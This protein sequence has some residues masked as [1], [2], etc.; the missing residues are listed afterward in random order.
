MELK[1]TYCCDGKER[2]TVTDK[3]VKNF[4]KYDNKYFCSNKCFTN[5][6]NEK[7]SNKRA[8]RS[9]WEKALNDIEELNKKTYEELSQVY[10]RDKLYWFLL[11]E[12]DVNSLPSYMYTKFDAITKGS[13]KLMKK[14]IPYDELLDMWQR[15]IKVFKKRKG[16]NQYEPLQLINYD[17]EILLSKYDSYKKWK[18]KEKIYQEQST[19]EIEKIKQSSVITKSLC[20]PSSKK[21]NIDDEMDDIL[22]EIFG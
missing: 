15:K 10:Y 16:R 14:G 17:L 4:I 3:N 18:E 19:L 21:D 5:F 6:C 7:L 2:I 22:D 13:Y 11:E 20:K 8:K 12:Y 1:C 9:K